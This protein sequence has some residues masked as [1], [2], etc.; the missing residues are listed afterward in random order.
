MS[1]TAPA[2]VVTDIGKVE[3]R[4]LKIPVRRGDEVRI[5]AMYSLLSPGTEMSIA[6]GHRM[7]NAKFPYVPG[8]QG[9]GRIVEVGNKVKGFEEGSV[10]MYLGGRT[11]APVNEVWGG[12]SANHCMRNGEPDSDSTIT[13]T[14]G[15]GACTAFCRWD[16]RGKHGAGCSL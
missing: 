2:L 9:V 5:E 3:I 16:A 6:L 14:G 11:Q 12:A 13:G 10:V 7:E 8:Y 1:K 15:C 4:E